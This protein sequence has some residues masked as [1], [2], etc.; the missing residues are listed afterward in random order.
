MGTRVDERPTEIDVGETGRGRAAAASADWD[1]AFAAF[2]AADEL[3]RLDAQDLQ[4]WATAAFLLGRVDASL[5]A[6]ARAHRLHLD[7]GNVRSAVRCGFWAG[8]QL[9]ARGDTAQAAGWLARCA[10]VAGELPAESAERGYLLIP[11]AFRLAAVEE[12]WAEAYSV[13][14]HV[15]DI[16]RREADADLMALA[17]TLAGRSLIGTGRA[18]DGMTLLDEAMLAV[19]SGELSPMVSGTVYCSLIEACEE[20]AEWPRAMEWTE[21]LA[22][23][24][25]RQHGMVTFTGQCLTHRAHILRLRGRFEA[26]AEAAQLAWERFAGA[27]EERL[28]GGAL[29]QAGEVHRLRGDFRRAEEAYR[30]AGEQ[31]HD[32]QPGL[33]LIRLA[34][35]RVEAAAATLRRAEVESV[36]PI[37]R[38]RLLPAYVE[39]LLA[40]GD[41]PA[42]GRAAAELR[43]LA[44]TYRTVALRADADCAEGVVDL[45]GGDFEAALTSLRRA[46][47]GWRSLGI[48]Y[49][50]ARARQLIAVACRALGDDETATLELEAAHRTLTE[51]GAPVDHAHSSAPSSTGRGGH[52]LSTRELEVLRLVATGMTNPAIADALHVAVKT[53][54]RHVAHILTKLG[55]PTR[56]AATAYAYEHD[57]LHAGDG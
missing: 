5:H 57:L 56:T 4:N 53:V 22:R 23:W 17:L 11:E 29:Y 9:L 24:C 48:P 7:H 27:P 49:E 10:R 15:A 30:R 20:I 1:E 26:A 2:S 42:A 44:G 14:A 25:D 46:A 12:R 55:V 37:D 28:S 34:Q 36:R 51:L 52:G 19:V 35:G 21:A 13:A 31:G 6:L 32:P 8:F 50:T 41:V 54:D 43:R 39:V 47:E 3:S 33:A 45:A 18:D 40:A 16:G 38:I